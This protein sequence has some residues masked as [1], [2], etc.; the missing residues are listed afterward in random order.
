MQDDTQSVL[1]QTFGTPEGIRTLGWLMAEAGCFDND[2]LIEDVKTVNFMNGVLRKMGIYD[3]ANVGSIA[4][5]LMN[6]PVKLE[7]EQANGT[8]K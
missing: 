8:D 4:E 6:I 1:R 3:I 5:A 7:G 2:L